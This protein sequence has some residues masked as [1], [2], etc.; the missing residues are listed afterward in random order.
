VERHGHGET[1]HSDNHSALQVATALV[2]MAHGARQHQQSRELRYGCH[3]LDLLEDG[4][5][6][7]DESTRP[8]ART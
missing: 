4:K 6:E 1:E 2:N 3:L 7:N 8:A 5:C